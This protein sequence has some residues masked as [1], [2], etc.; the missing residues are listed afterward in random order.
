MIEIAA[1]EI[2]KIVYRLFIGGAPGFY[3][4]LIQSI[5]ATGTV[6]QRY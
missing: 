1:I 3:R 5:E 2:V 4:K 6:K